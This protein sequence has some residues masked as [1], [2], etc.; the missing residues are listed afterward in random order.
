LFWEADTQKV[1]RQYGHRE[2]TDDE[3]LKRILDGA[4]QDFIKQGKPDTPVIIDGA[5]EVPWQ[6]IYTVVNI[7]KALEIEKIEF[8]MGASAGK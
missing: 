1:R 2:V 5:F 6:S 8:A 7:C 4:H 3:E